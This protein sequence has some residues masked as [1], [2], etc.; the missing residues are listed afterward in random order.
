MIRIRFIAAWTLFCF[1]AIVFAGAVW[2]TV[3]PHEFDRRVEWVQLK[4]QALLPQPP[5]PEFV[6][7][8]LAEQEP[9]STPTLPANLPQ[10][11]AASTRTAT[12]RAVSTRPPVAASVSLPTRVA[13]SDFR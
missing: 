3:V 10:P 9:I 6:P 12:P 2:A 8:P 5:R 13:L 1:A 11:T 4:I 7:T